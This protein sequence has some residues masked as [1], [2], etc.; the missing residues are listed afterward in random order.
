MYAGQSQVGST[1]STAV[2]SGIPDSNVGY[3]RAKLGAQ[4]LRDAVK[5]ALKVT[6]AAEYSGASDI[7]GAALQMGRDLYTGGWTELTIVQVWANGSYARHWEPGAVQDYFSMLTSTLYGAMPA[8]LR[9]RFYF[10]WDQGESEAQDADAQY[11]NEWAAKYTAIHSALQTLCGQT[12]AR[13]IIP[14]RSGLTG[15][16]TAEMHDT[17]QPSVADYTVSQDSATTVDGTHRDSPSNNALGSALATLL[18]TL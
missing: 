17:I 13:I 11:K 9:P 2:P 14:V 3:W 8:T 15:A 12:L 6:T 1:T 7:A 10:I 16:H 4:P 18:L 5:Q